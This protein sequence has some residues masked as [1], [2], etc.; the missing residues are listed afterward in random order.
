[1][2]RNPYLSYIR[3]PLSLHS[4]LVAIGNCIP[5]LENLLSFI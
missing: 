2:N 4:A 1:M 5:V 3:E